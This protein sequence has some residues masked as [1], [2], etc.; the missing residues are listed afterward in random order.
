MRYA[1]SLLSVVVVL[2]YV[3]PQVGKTNDAGNTSSTNGV[4]V[5]GDNA[6]AQAARFAASQV[7]KSYGWGGTG[8]NRY[9]CSGLTM[10]SW[11]SAGVTIPR[12]SYR[13]QD[14][15][16]QVSRSN[17]R[18]G[19]LVFSNYRGRNGNKADHVSIYVGE[20]K[21]VTSSGGQGKVVF[22]DLSRK[23]SVVSYG[24]PA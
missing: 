13:Q 20:G 22:R 1:L 23:N 4:T 16:T 18:P 10:K 5:Q 19:D 24:R 7:G 2:L 11:Q 6:G 9:D 12:V 17:L 14:S 15:L 3:A 8:P 21:V